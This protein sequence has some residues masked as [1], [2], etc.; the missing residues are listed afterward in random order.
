M[1]KW[2]DMKLKSF[3]TTKEMASKLE[4]PPQSGRKYLPAIEFSFNQ[5]LMVASKMAPK[6][7]LHGSLWNLQLLFYM[8]KDKY[9]LI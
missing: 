8:V 4:R 9:Y 6:K 5:V 1:D 7:Y 2:D 3:C